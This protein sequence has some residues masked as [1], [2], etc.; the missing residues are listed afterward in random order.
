MPE[1]DRVG[2]GQQEVHI[3]GTCYADNT[4]A[5]SKSFEGLQVKADFLAGVRAF[6]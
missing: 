4:Q 1:P 2:V 6:V 3:G 5:M